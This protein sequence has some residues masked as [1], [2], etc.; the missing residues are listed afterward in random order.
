MPSA[1]REPSR[2]ARDLVGR[3]VAAHRPAPASSPRRGRLRASSRGVAGPLGDA[4]VEV[5]PS[6]RARAQRVE[7][8]A[9]ARGPARGFRIARTFTRAPRRPRSVSSTMRSAVKRSRKR[10]RP[11]APMRARRARSASSSTSACGQ[12]RAGRA[13]G[14]AARHAVLHGLGDAARGGGHDGHGRTPSRRAGSCRAPR[15]ATRGRRRRRPGSRRSRSLRKPAKTHAVGEAQRRAPAPRARAAARPRPRSRS[16]ASGTR[17]S[18]QR[19]GLE[20]RRVV[21]VVR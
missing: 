17:A 18:T 2:P 20:Q 5:A 10:R 16:R 11:A 12:R 13:A 4:Q 14:P 21:L 8:A 7:R 9:R 15:G 3:A 1:V 19:R 6:G